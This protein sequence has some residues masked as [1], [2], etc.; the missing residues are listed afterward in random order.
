MNCIQKANAWNLAFCRVEFA[1]AQHD[2]KKVNLQAVSQNKF[3]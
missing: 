1:I 3:S 2:K